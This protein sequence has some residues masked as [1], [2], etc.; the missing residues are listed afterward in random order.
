V[1]ESRH[2]QHEREV[3][4]AQLGQAI[5]LLAWLVFAAIVLA[6]AALVARELDSGV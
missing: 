5:G 2:D 1:N 3:R 6:L 4:E